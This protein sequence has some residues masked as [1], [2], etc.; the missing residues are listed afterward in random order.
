MSKGVSMKVLRKTIAITLAA[1]VAVMAP[2]FASYAAAA[3]TIMEGG[4]GAKPVVLPRL[5]VNGATT[6]G[7]QALNV[8]PGAGVNTIING[9]EA[10]AKDASLNSAPVQPGVL[11]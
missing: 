3:D 4:A 1:A 6:L 9:I 5:E 2:G 11:P 10:G 8:I 7:T